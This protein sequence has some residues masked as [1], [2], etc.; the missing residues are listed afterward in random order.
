MGRRFGGHSQVAGSL[1]L[2]LEFH[3]EFAVLELQR[4]NTL[5]QVGNDPVEGV[6]EVFAVRDAFFQLLTG[7]VRFS[8]H[9]PSIT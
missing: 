6:N 3:H 4:E 8:T 5:L 2:L 9:A 1:L 7:C